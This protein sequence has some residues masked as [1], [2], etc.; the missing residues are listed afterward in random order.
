MKSGKLKSIVVLI[1]ISVLIHLGGCACSVQI[2]GNSDSDDLAN[3]SRRN[4]HYVHVGE[5]TD[6]KVTLEPD[7]ASYVIVD[8][9][10][11]LFFAK[12]TK[13]GVYSFEKSFDEKWRGRKCN[14]VV[15]A[16]RQN[17]K[18]DYR[19]RKGIVKK[20]VPYM[21]PPDDLL[22]Q[23]TMQIYCYQSKIIL[24]VRTSNRKEPNWNYGK[25]MIFGPDEKVS[26]IKYG[27]P[28]I[29]GFTAFGPEWSSGAY[30]VFYEPK[31]DQVHRFG[32]THVRFTVPD[33]KTKKKITVEGYISTP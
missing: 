13:A 31:A 1:G 20:F 26:V 9:C 11:N 27:K 7:I 16:F 12:K 4:P 24:K 15:R 30:I 2:W 19:E 32:R 14:V 6:F 17:G 21:D 22:C 23:A 29:D 33:P 10:G 3:Y 28:G 8:F 5:I 25:L 18:R